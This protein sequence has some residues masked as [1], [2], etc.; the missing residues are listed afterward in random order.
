M[1]NS[2]PLPLEISRPRKTRNKVRNQIYQMEA[3]AVGVSLEGI[4]EAKNDGFFRVANPKLSGYHQQQ[5][6]QQ[7]QKKK[8][9]Q[10]QQQQKLHQQK[11]QQQQQNTP[12]NSRRFRPLDTAKRRLTSTV[13]NFEL[14]VVPKADEFGRAQIEE[15]RRNADNTIR[16]P[17]KWINHM[18]SR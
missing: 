1:K 14:N 18:F 2:C 11:Q 6:Q 16:R 7:K 8:Q 13:R 12:T 9:Q 5:N 10:K 17:L 15:V 4:K 3:T